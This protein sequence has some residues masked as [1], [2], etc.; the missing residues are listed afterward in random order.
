MIGTEG[1]KLMGIFFQE[2]DRFL[3]GYIKSIM[4]KTMPNRPI[5]G[6]I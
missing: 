4:T 3:C 2:E 6:N 5:N 1:G